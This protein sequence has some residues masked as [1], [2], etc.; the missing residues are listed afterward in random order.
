MMTTG[1]LRTCSILPLDVALFTETSEL[2]LWAEL[3]DHYCPTDAIIGR[4]TGI[5]LYYTFYSVCYCET[6]TVI[7]YLPILVCVCIVM[8]FV[9]K[10]LHS[11][12]ILEMTNVVQVH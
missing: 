2:K 9:L 11:F 12:P 5:E 10:F 8:S 1:F 6:V 3:L 4:D 7:D